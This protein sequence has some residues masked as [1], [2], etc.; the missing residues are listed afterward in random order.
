MRGAI[1]LL[2]LHDLM[3][4]SWKTLRFRGTVLMMKTAEGNL[5]CRSKVIRLCPVK[6]TTNF[7]FC[8]RSLSFLTAVSSCMQSVA[9]VAGSGTE[10]FC[11]MLGYYYYYY[12]Y[13]SRLCHWN[14]SVT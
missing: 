4:W 6:N 8:F 13:Y 5:L 11:Q 2:L 10:N 7:M 3:S 14:F 12:Y 9:L 1:A